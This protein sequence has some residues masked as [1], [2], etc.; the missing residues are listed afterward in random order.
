MD[1]AG[2]VFA[3][4]VTGELRV[5]RE[6]RAALDQRGTTIVTSSSALVTLLSGIAAFA[7]LKEGNPKPSLLT[8]VLFS[9]TLALFTAAAFCGLFAN[10]SRG[11]SFLPA[12]NL[13][14]LRDDNP[15]DQPAD[16]GR[17]LLY[18][19]QVE[20]LE[21]LRSGNERKSAFVNVGLLLQLCALA[22][23]AVTIPASMNDLLSG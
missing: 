16:D 7:A 8:I 6:R 10:V 5:E 3:E 11:F 9:A 19:F 13:L 23:L 15:W 22:F 18:R 20:Q 1:G 17:R 12:S 2:L 21:T 4:Y 14:R